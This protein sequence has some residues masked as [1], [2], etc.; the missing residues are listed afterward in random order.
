[1]DQNTG[2]MGDHPSTSSS[3]NTSPYLRHSSRQRF[4]L[5]SVATLPQYTPFVD[6]NTQ[7]T[8]AE[9]ADLEERVS[10]SLV[11]LT[12]P[13]DAP[14][15]TNVN[16]RF[17]TILNHASRN[18]SEL[19]SERTIS[20]TRSPDYEYSYSNQ[21]NKPWATLKLYTHDLTLE[22]NN[23]GYNQPRMPY[24]GSS[25][26]LSGLIQLDINNPINIHQI[27]LQVGLTLSCWIKVLT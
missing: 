11:P 7:S 19:P 16:P 21:A 8:S 17:S 18:T 12:S 15:Y 4:S 6:H 10:V 3:D 2:G 23:R 20:L 5:L 26:P 1:M 13:T 25:E 9:G 22:R 14:Q 24:V 27:N